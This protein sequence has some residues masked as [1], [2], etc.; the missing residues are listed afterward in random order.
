[1][2]ELPRVI[3]FLSYSIA[4][5]DDIW[6]TGKQYLQTPI[7]NA[8][9]YCTRKDTHVPRA[10]RDLIRSTLDDAKV[11]FSVSMMGLSWRS[12]F[13]LQHHTAVP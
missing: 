5:P 4:L 13:R 9:I 12:L 2:C 8:V 11:T 3:T 7:D 6:E 1:M 10:G